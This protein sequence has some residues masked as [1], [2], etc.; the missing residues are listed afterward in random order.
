MVVDDRIGERMRVFELARAHA[1]RAVREQTEAARGAEW[2]WWKACKELAGV[3]AEREKQ[4]WEMG[5]EG[6]EDG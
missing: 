5:L 6:E 2:Q 4:G 3:G 1:E